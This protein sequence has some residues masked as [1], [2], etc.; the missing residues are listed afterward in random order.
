MNRI[1]VAYDGSPASRRALEHATGLIGD[2]ELLLVHVL[3]SLVP[4]GYDPADI[5]PVEVTREADELRA[6]ADDL[7]SRGLR[8]RALPIASDAFADP[9]SAILAVAAEQGATMIAVGSRGHGALTRLAMG[10]VST[11]LAHECRCDVLI[12]R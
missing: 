1:L 12:V 3:D 10:S 5:D 7:T 11:R 2:G 6:I 8:V 4:E 9:V